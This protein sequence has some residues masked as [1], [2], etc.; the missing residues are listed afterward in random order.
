MLPASPACHEEKQLNFCT[1]P[2]PSVLF[3]YQTENYTS[4]KNIKK[5]TARSL[6][7]ARL[8]PEGLPK[9][10]PFKFK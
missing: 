8:F 4:A 1:A 5:T 3:H 9:L 2:I 10:A 7:A 6:I